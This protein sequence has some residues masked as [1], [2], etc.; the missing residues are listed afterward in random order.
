M[1]KLGITCSKSSSKH[2]KQLFVRYCKEEEV[3]EKNRIFLLFKSQFL[4]KMQ[5]INSNGHNLLLFKK[6]N[7]WIE[8]N[9]E[10]LYE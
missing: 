5:H 4:A 8:D 1:D 6:I 10:D 3:M 2:N 7:V 9:W